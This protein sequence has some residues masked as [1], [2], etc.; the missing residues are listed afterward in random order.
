MET[1]QNKLNFRNF[2]FIY[3]PSVLTVL[4]PFFLITGPFLPDLSISL[5]GILFIINSLS[6]SSEN[7][8]IYYKSK[9]FIFFI[10]FWLT[11]VV[12]SLL[13][14]DVSYSLQTSIFYIRFGFF[15]LSTW[16]LLNNNP[17]IIIAFFYAMV[18]CFFILIIDGSIQFFYGKNIFGWEIIGTRISSF[19]KD[20]LVL[21]SY[22]SR[23]FPLF[24][25]VYIFIT[26]N[27][28]NY[29]YNYF[30]LIIF[31]LADVIVFLS[32]ER[33][34]FFYLNLSAIFIFFLSKK[35]K[36]IRILILLISFFIMFV[37][38][39]FQDQYKTRIIDKTLN[40]FQNDNNFY[41][42]SIEHQ[43]HY[44]SAILMF[45]DNKF[46]GIGPKLFRKNCNKEKY[47]V[48]SQSCSTHPHNTY[49]QL[50]AE[51]GIIGFLQLFILFSILVY[52]CFKHLF[53]LINQKILLFNEFQVALLSCI[54]I[55]LWPFTPTGN[56]FGN[57]INIIYYL[58][59]GFFLFSLNKKKRC[60]F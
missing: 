51:V 8:K 31:V 35:Y 34:A 23:L 37:I 12:S 19:F 16:F 40:Q 50:L 28:N 21:G 20:E 1:M 3:L 10:I 47:I 54:L 14:N 9:F 11:L 42:F 26:E 60:N 45:K 52:F 55:T 46:I 32:G 6:N 5:C 13:S 29:L 43:N 48:H 41:I 58:P 44:K 38:T 15:T 25:A 53:L 57:W 30:V 2:F 49:V 17:K 39:L 18:F 24:F 22:I 59:I 27:K 7:F 33:V 36:K 4:L 56:F